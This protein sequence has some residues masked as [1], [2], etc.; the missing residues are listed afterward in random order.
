MK[1]NIVLNKCYRNLRTNI[2]SD[3]DLQEFAEVYIKFK[4]L[5]FQY[6]LLKIC[7]KLEKISVPVIEIPILRFFSKFIDFMRWKIYDIIMLCINGKSFSLY[8]V[9]CFCGRQRR[10]ENY[11]NS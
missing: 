10:R 2:F 9:T 4:K 3:L 11:W 8:G 7:E 6:K 5:K 1:K